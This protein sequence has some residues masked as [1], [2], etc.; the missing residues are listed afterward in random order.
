MFE[1]AIM[2]GLYSITPVHAG[3]GTEISAIDLPIQ[4]ERH[5]NFPII[6]GQS[7]KGV[8]RSEYKRYERQQGEKIPTE[9]IFGPESGTASEYAGAISV[10]DAKVLLFPVRSLKG[11]FAY[12]TCPMVLERLRK[13]VELAFG[14]EPDVEVPSVK[15]DEAV[16]S[17][18]LLVVVDEDGRIVLED[19]ALISS[20]NELREIIEELKKLMP[21]SLAHRLDERLVVVSDDVFKALV[22][23]TTELEARIRIGSSGTVEQGALWYE[24]FLPT[25]SL[26]YSMI[27]VADTKKND[28]KTD[29]KDIERALRTFLHKRFFQI[30]GDETVGKGFVSVSVHG[31]GQDGQA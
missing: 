7:L 9:L 24:E 26:L 13:D 8:L 12:I 5:T 19:I 28:D 25:D 6:W 29:A 23:T 30:G 2:V 10:G 1:R 4:R 20:N 15:E 11:V 3:S 14:N 31:G 17:G 16:V 18:D 22:S 27:A 21:E